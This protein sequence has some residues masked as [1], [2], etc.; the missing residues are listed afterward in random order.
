MN[1]S[2]LRRYLLLLFLASIFLFWGAG[3]PAFQERTREATLI[4]FQGKVKI[5]REGKEGLEKTANNLALF[6]GD[7]VMTRERSSAQ[8]SLA[9]GSTIILGANSQLYLNSK[10]EEEELVTSLVLVWGHLW[11]KVSPKTTGSS[12]NIE[13]S[14]AIAA[15]YGTSFSVG[16]ALDGTTRIGV[17]TGEV[18][19][20]E[21]NG[22]LTLKENQEISLEPGEEP[23]RGFKPSKI[24]PQEYKHR[25]DEDWEVWQK[26]ITDL[27]FQNPAAISLRMARRLEGAVTRERELL[28]QIDDETNLLGLR[29]EEARKARKKGDL[30]TLAQK[31]EE[32]RA[33]AQALRK[34]I[35][36]LRRTNNRLTTVFELGQELRRKALEEKKRLGDNLPQV[37]ANFKRIKVAA[38]KVRLAQQEVHRLLKER[39]PKLHQQSKELMEEK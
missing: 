20:E 18:K 11:A 22:S 35:F 30:E 29:L 31:R 3:A 12:F 2:N 36:I 16:V 39:S 27:F 5:Q 7:A 32:I 23:H 37:K 19:V 4:S 24:V 14:T 13:T 8:I 34:S 1:R 38:Q 21:V 15:A 17:E 28:K 9:D 25:T 10:V 33:S 6:S 26:R